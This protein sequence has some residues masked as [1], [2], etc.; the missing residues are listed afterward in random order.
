MEQH[1]TAKQRAFEEKEEIKDTFL[2]CAPGTQ[3]LLPADLSLNDE[4]VI[5]ND[6]GIPEVR[7]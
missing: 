4:K 1:K 7:S 5:Y 2:T 3:V 6:F